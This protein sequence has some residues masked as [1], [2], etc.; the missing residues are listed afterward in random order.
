MVKHEEHSRLR[1]DFLNQTGPANRLKKEMQYCFICVT[2]L[3]SYYILETF[4]VMD[5]F[6]NI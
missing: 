5:D 4:V 6:S 2:G 1:S 3:V